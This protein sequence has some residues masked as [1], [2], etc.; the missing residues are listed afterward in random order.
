MFI[1]HRHKLY[2]T[3]DDPLPDWHCPNCL[4]GLLKLKP[5]TIHSK[6]GT[7]YGLLSCPA[8]SELV[9]VMGNVREENHGYHPYLT[10]SYID[11]YVDVY[12]PLYF[13]PTVPIFRVAE[14]C[15]KHILELI[16]DS[17][18]AFWFS[19]PLCAAKIREAIEILLTEN[20][21]VDVNRKRKSV[22]LR[23]RIVQFGDIDNETAESMLKTKWL[24]RAGSDMSRVQKNELLSAFELLEKVVNRLY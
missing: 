23:S 12:R 10:D 2:F 3:K 13:N 19:S 6:E 1:Q 17:F 24:G 18:M 8:C 5:D 16:K 22:T 14:K 7:F 9:Y 4:D 15:P 21:R 11:V 20:Q